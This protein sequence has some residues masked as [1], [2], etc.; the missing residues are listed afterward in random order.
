MK[1]EIIEYLGFDDDEK[2]K[3]GRPKLADKKTKRNSLI[4]ASL[5]FVFVIL[6]LIFG[7]GTLFGFKDINLKGSIVN[8]NESDNI[9][10][11]DIKPLVNDITDRKSVV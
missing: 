10:V 3:V 1:K 11:E 6:L 9:L 7:Y 8:K 2:L 5:S 4:V